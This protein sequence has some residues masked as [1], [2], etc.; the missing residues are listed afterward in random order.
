MQGTFAYHDT[1]VGSWRRHPAQWTTRVVDESAEPPEAAYVDLIAERSAA[2][3]SHRSR[4]TRSHQRLHSTHA[5]R[6]MTNRWRLALLGATN[7][8]VAR[9]AVTLIRSGRPRSVGIA[10]LGLA[11]WAVGSDLEWLQLRRGRVG[12]PSRRHVHA[13]P[14]PDQ[15]P[16]VDN[17]HVPV[18]GG[19]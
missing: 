5:D 6:A 17:S 2:A 4:Q 15:S 7:R 1:P 16:S 12:W 9:M 11:M 19:Q 3:A 13:R 14:C 18:S 8:D 10:L